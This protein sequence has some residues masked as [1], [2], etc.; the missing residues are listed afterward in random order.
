MEPEGLLI[1]GARKAAVAARELWWRAR[2]PQARGELPLARVK[3]RLELV[4]GALYGETPVILPS[5]PPPRPTWLARVLGRAPR[6][7]SPRSAQASTDGSSVWLPRAIETGDDE[8]A[9]LATYRLLALE[10]VARAARGSPPPPRAIGS[11]TI[12][13]RSRRPR[14][15]IGSWP[16]IRWARGR[17][18]RGPRTRAARAALARAADGAGA[19]RRAAGPGDALGESRD[20][21]ARGPRHGD[22]RG[23]TPLGARRRGAAAPHSHALSRRGDRPALGPAACRAAVGERSAGGTR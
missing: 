13:T 14:R 1:D 10:Q 17:P 9:A 7:L 19:P 3:R 21:A 15:W 23:V 4:V 5:D 6:H 8:G 16:A 12:S 11:S 2:P 18:A 20:A 22:A